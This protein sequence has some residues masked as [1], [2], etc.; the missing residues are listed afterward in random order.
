MADGTCEFTLT[1]AE[2]ADAHPDAVLAE[3][4]LNEADDWECP[5][6]A[7]AEDRCLAHLDEVPAEINE[8]DWVLDAVEATAE[9]QRD[10]RQ[11]KQFLAGTFE[12]LDLVSAATEQQDTHPLDFRFAE[13]RSL[14]CAE[15]DLTEDL[16]VGMAVVGELRLEGDFDRLRGLAADICHLILD[17]VAIKQLVLRDASLGRLS[18]RNGDAGLLDLRN[19]IAAELDL[20][21]TEVDR[22]HCEFLTAHDARGHHATFEKVDFDNATF[23]RVDFYYAD[24]NEADF[25]NVAATDAVFK[26]TTFDG[27][28]FNGSE[29]ELANWIGADVDSGHFGEMRFEQASFYG[30]SFGSGRFGDTYFGLAN[31]EDASF[32]WADFSGATL[33][34]GVFRAAEFGTAEFVRV[35]SAGA[36]NLKEIVV[37]EEID[38]RPTSDVPPSD[39]L[40][41]LEESELNAGELAQPEDGRAIYDLEDAT[42]GDIR[43][44]GTG[45]D[46][47]LVRSVHFLRTRFEGFD[48]RDSDDIDL[49][50]VTYNLHEMFDGATRLG[51]SLRRYGLALART[52]ETL[53]RPRPSTDRPA[54]V[55]WDVSSRDYRDLRTRVHDRLDGQSARPGPL[56]T[57][58]GSSAADIE[59][60]YLLAKNGAN[61]I[62]DNESSAEFFVR[63]MKAR[64]RRHAELAASADGLGSSLGHRFDQAKNLIL[65]A[66]AGYG[67]SPSRVILTSGVIIGVFWLVFNGLAPGLYDSQLDYLALTIGSFVTLIIGGIGEIPN[68]GVRLLSQFEAFVGAFLIA[69]FVFTLTRAIHR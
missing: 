11:R 34:Q 49:K 3:E 52:K 26:G 19:A 58:G 36:L 21:E 42:V 56:P 8:T 2:R 48:F 7:V 51:A 33:E 63:E 43:F 9:N 32:D 66:S 40:V 20:D 69:M 27:A 35:D 60:T 30:A 55:A 18:L 4:D 10:R 29:F 46:V 47:E 28:Y 25:R 45:D 31:F 12:E 65:G 44:A 1:A 62:H 59:Y 23:E 13:I 37:D 14:N 17:D 16:D 6:D 15:L 57:F 41:D 22:G 67:E 54:A 5:H 38:I 50:R 39:S 61:A 24:F 53:D 64:Y 68:S